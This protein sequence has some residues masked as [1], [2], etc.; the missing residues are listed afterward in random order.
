MR[1]K[2]KYD[3]LI[4]GAGLFGCVCAKELTDRGCRVLVIDRRKHVGGNCAV[5]TVNGQPEHVYG[6]HIFHTDKKFIWDY[7]N[8]I[9]EFIPYKH[10]VVAVH[11]GLQYDFPIN[12][13]T[14]IKVFGENTVNVPFASSASP[15]NFEEAAVSRI[16]ERLYRMFYHDYTAKQWGRDPTLLPA[17]IFSRV[18]VRF[19]YSDSYFNDKYTGVLSSNR[20]FEKL[21]NGA[22]LKLNCA[23]N[24]RKHRE[25]ARGIIYTGM[26]D[27]YENY[28]LGRLPYRSLR[29]EKRRV[30]P[31]EN[32]GIAVV[33]FTDARPY[34]RT[35]EYGYMYGRS[36][37]GGNRWYEYPIGEFDQKGRKTEPYYPLPTPEA[38][39]LYHEYVELIEK[40]F[41]GQ[42]IIIKFG[43]R[44]GSYQYINMD[45]AVEQALHL[46]EEIFTQ[47]TFKKFRGE[48]SYA[49]T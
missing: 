8:D 33:N 6:P 21:L 24:K 14:L 40:D 13:F 23:F 36:Q 30:A 41:E 20:L 35:C 15:S 46:V 32:Q 37:I 44:L 49:R 34:T 47:N 38:K 45:Q 42:D 9:E 10:R 2:K 28:C 39:G 22:S 26:V 31:Y 16:G 27:E 3:F 7:L 5:R 29:F 48:N 17:E 25:I 12:R 4:V 1:E 11:G 19:D 43:G 18:P